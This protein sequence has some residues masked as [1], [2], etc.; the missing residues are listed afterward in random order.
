[1]RC[2]SFKLIVKVMTFTKW[3]VKCSAHPLSSSY[4]DSACFTMCTKYIVKTVSTFKRNSKRNVTI[5]FY[6]NVHLQKG[7]ISIYKVHVDTPV[8][9][10]LVLVFTFPNNLCTCR[11]WQCGGSY[12]RNNSFSFISIIFFIFLLRRKQRETKND[13]LFL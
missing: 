11:G 7:Y 12:V 2:T 3:I 4:M 1:M 8:W 6:K 5:P 10:R 9:N 13:I